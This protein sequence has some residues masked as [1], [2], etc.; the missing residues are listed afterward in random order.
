M[1][2]QLLLDNLLSPPILFFALG[3]LAVAARSDLEVPQPIAKFLSLYLLFAIG[4]HGGHAL[5]ESGVTATVATALGAALV[6]AV[7]VPVYSF[8]VLRLRIDAANAAAIAATYGSVSAVTFVTA[9]AFLQRVGIE[10]GG[11][12][13]AAMALME[14]PA[15]VIGVLLLRTSA[16]ARKR[17]ALPLGELVREASFN[18]SVVLILGS[19]AIGVVTGERGWE[20]MRPFAGDIFKGILAFFLL[21]MGILAARRLGDLRAGGWFLPAFAAVMPLVNAAFGVGVAY[22]AGLPMGDAIMFV[23]LCA[24]ASYIAVPAAMRL[25]VP[26]ASPSLYVSMSL[27]ITFPLNIVLGIPLYAWI[28][29]RLWQ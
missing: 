17:G 26:E 25:A 4:L 23:V 13:V 1:T 7:V 8:Y 21:D 14:A 6:M 2:L 16:A 3:G 15:I 24:S 19:L 11:H 9:A 22:L 18:G 5:A 10:F 27:G 20:A 12:M 29:Q 28:V